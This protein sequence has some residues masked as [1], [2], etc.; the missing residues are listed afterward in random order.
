M[1]G[2]LTSRTRLD[3][4]PPPGHVTVDYNVTRSIGRQ[5]PSGAHALCIVHMTYYPDRTGGHTQF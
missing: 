4:S 3:Q 1:L 5:Q 2:L